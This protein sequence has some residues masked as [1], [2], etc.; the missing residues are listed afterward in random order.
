MKFKV[1]DRVKLVNPHSDFDRYYYLGDEFVIHNYCPMENRYA[2][3]TPGGTDKSLWYYDEDE[4]ELVHPEY[5]V[6]DKVRVVTPRSIGEKQYIGDVHEIIRIEH[7]LY[8][9]KLVESEKPDRFLVKFVWYWW[10][11]EVW[12]KE[13][14]KPRFDHHNYV[15]RLYAMHCP[16]KESADIFLRYMEDNGINGYCKC[17][18]DTFGE[19]TCYN[20]NRTFHDRLSYYK[21][22]GF[23]VLEFDDFDWSDFVIGG[24]TTKEKEKKLRDF[25][26]GLRCCECPLQKADMNCGHLYDESFRYSVNEIN[27]MYEKVFG[28]NDMKKFTKKDLKNGD[29]VKCRDGKVGIVI[30]DLDCIVFYRK[31]FMLDI[32]NH[33]LTSALLDSDDIMEVR[34]AKSG[35][36]CTFNAFDRFYALNTELV[37]ERKEV[38]EMTLAEVCKAL[39]KEIKIVKEK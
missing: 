34:R 36:H 4:L 25:C 13:P 28:G 11:D 15:N 23:T 7:G 1:G 12:L 3:K 27:E 21:D 33:N 29:V 19:S 9:T 39:G 8:V 5:K 35:N 6:G 2:V 20:I 24:S 37:F 18:W 26:R 10:R 30:L 32:Y 17:V 38:E 14:A 16:T 22:N 31:T